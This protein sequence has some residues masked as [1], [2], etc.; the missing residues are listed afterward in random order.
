MIDNPYMLHEFLLKTAISLE[1]LRSRG[2]TL[3]IEISDI[4]RAFKLGYK[5]MEDHNF[6]LKPD[7]L[8]HVITLI[9]RSY[10]TKFKEIVENGVDVRSKKYDLEFL[11]NSIRKV[12]GL[13]DVPYKARYIEMDNLNVV[14]SLVEHLPQLLWLKF[15]VKDKEIGLYCTY[16]DCLK[17]NLEEDGMDWENIGY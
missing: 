12:D 17:K 16:R 3:T 1:Q 6:N 10:Y 14:V 9:D 7:S 4:I 5:M 8:H 13:K 11:F 2:E 15:N